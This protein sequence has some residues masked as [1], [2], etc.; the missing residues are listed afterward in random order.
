MACNVRTVG[1]KSLLC[2]RNKQRMHYTT[3]TRKERCCTQCIG[4][5]KNV[6]EGEANP[7]PA[8]TRVKCAW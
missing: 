5:Q 3:I 7:F 1:M 8:V 4:F 2:M 6:W